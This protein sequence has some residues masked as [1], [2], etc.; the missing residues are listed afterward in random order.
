MIDLRFENEWEDQIPANTDLVALSLLWDMPLRRILDLVRRLK[1]L[2]PGVRVAAGGRVAE[3]NRKALVT[4]PEGERLD[5]VFSGPDDGRFRVFVECGS[6]EKL[7]GV[8]FFQNGDY[9]QTPLTPY[10]PIPDRPLPDRSL[11][12]VRYGMI[13]R[14]GLDLGIATDT[15]Q[16]S[17]GCPFHCAFCTF[18]RD[19]EGRQITYTARSPESVADELGEIDAPYVVF[20]D[21]LAFHRPDRMGRLCDILLERRIRKIYGIETRVNMGMRPDIVEKMARTGFRHVTF[22][23]ESMHNHVLKFLNKGSSRH[24]IE[25]AFADIRHVPMFFV[26]N[27][28]IGSVGETREQMLQIPEFAHKIGLDSI[29]IHPLRCFGTEPLTEKVLATPGYY[30]DPNSRR[31]YSDQLSN[32]EIGRIA[33]KIKRDFWTPTQKLKTA[34]KVK[35]LFKP[36]RASSIA[37]HWFSWKIQGQ[38]DPWGRNL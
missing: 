22:G 37:W 36:L 7:T 2:R 15:I 31:V 4:A 24:M 32:E 9:R 6:A 30:I 18:N 23:L 13:R 8:S 14:D 21:D 25:K 3:A 34:W 1:E 38:P 28:I 26:A 27:F 16:S 17:R 33:R 12:R 11:R 35:R 29:M 20:V 5:M 19:S 10:G